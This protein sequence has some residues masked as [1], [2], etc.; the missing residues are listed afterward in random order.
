M[1]VIDSYLLLIG[2]S[3]QNAETALSKFAE[4]PQNEVSDNRVCACVRMCMRT[5]VFVAWEYSVSGRHGDGVSD[6][7]TGSESS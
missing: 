1:K 7:E 4:L 3:R 6:S 2:Q 5:F